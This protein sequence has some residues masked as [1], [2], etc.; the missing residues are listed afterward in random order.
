M[1]TLPCLHLAK[2]CLDSL[3]AADAREIQKVFLDHVHRK[4]LPQWRQ[5]SLQFRTVSIVTIRNRF[6]KQ[7]AA[8]SKGGLEAV[9]MP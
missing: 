6:L 5:F 4:H 7:A 1:T 2:E 8:D 9:R 3:S